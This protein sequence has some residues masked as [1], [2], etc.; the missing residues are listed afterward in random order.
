MKVERTADP[1]EKTG[2][3]ASGRSERANY[4]KVGAGTFKYTP[5]NLPLFG[6]VG[7][8]VAF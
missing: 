1:L 8:A 7:G 2:F 4:E 3:G 6:P 5:T